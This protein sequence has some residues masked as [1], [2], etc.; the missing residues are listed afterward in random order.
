VG[1]RGGGIAGRIGEGRG[2]RVGIKQCGAHFAQN[3]N[4]LP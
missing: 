4:S 2:R 3:S 1:D